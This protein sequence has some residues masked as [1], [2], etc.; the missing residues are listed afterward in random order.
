[1]F[2]R[3][4]TVLLLLTGI[5]SCIYGQTYSGPASGGVA[6]GATISTD[7]FSKNSPVTE[8]KEQIWNEETEYSGEQTEYIDF[9]YK[10]PK[11]GSNY[12]EDPNAD[13][14][15][16]STPFP[17]L[18]KDFDGIP[19]GNS[20]PPDP[21]I[22]VGP[23]NIIAVVNTS[24]RI[25][26]KEGN[27]LKTISADS[28]FNNVFTN[29]GAFDPKVLYDVID[30]RWI[31]VWLQQN[32][33]A[34]TA[35]LLLSVSDD[36]DPLGTWYNWA[37]PANLN[38]NTNSDT[39]TDYQG[40]GYDENAIY[41]TGN[42][43]SFAVGGV[44]TFQYAKIRIIPKAQLYANTAGPCSWQD[45]WNINNGNS[46]TIRP[47]LMYTSA[48]KYYMV[49][50]PYQANFIRVYNITDPLGTPA[51]GLNNIPVTSYT[52]PGNP[53][54]LGG[55]TNLE[56]GGSYLRNEP[57]FRDGFLYLV[58]AV[59]NPSSPGYSALHYVKVNVNTNTT[60]Q[61]YVFG[62]TG[63]WHFYPSID[64]DIN[65]NVALAYSRS[66]LNEYAGAF[67]TGRFLSDPPGFMGSQPIAEGQG[68]YVV[69]YGGDRNRWGDYTGIVL[70]PV[71]QTSFWALSEYV[72]ATNTWGTRVG[73]IS[74][75]PVAGPNL[76]SFIDSLDFGSIEVGT[77]STTL[78]IGMTNIGS[79]D[80][81]I[82]DVP[83]ELGPFHLLNNL[84]LPLT[85]STYDSLVLDYSYQPTET[86]PSAETVTITSNS[87]GFQDIL[88]KG[89]GYEIN[90]AVK[91]NFYA[92]SGNVNSGSLYTINPVTGAGN[93]IGNADYD[94]V[95]VFKSLTLDPHSGVLYGLSN[96]SGNAV[97][98]RINSAIGDA[99]ALYS[100][101]LTDMY[102]ITFDSS[103]TLYG[104]Q[105]TGEI[106][107]IDL[108]TGSYTFKDTADIMINSAAFDL[109]TNT[110]Y[111]TPYL[112][113][114]TNKD[115]I[116]TID[117]ETGTSTVVGNTGLNVLTNDLAFDASGNM[118]G[119]TGSASQSNDFISIDK[120]TGAGTI[121]GSINYPNI[122]GLAFSLTGITGLEP[123]DKPQ[124]PK[125]YSLKQNYPNPF[126]P[127]TKIEYTLPVAASVKVVIYN[128]LGEV[129]DVLVNSQ[130]NAGTHT[131]VWNSEDSHGNKAGSGV[132]FYELKANS[133]NGSDF[134]Q[135]RKMILLK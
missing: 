1:M 41:V 31:M 123:A 98:S 3:I 63:Y 21:Y 107:T 85:L 114:G 40:V 100:L 64:V 84:S 132:Y 24:F 99:Y 42:Q 101:P 68:N 71:D 91:D 118:Y 60:D 49:E 62:A 88:L 128:L 131:V 117:P 25:F 92:V 80:V 108:N 7:D 103:G 90:P 79:D 110:L 28:W 48:S 44:N 106:Y 113:I 15:N 8:P 54:Q 27:I 86:G 70:D 55:G 111:A 94:D 32:D 72:A 10:T 82:S 43:W 119:V 105:K 93:L 58:H 78:S 89:R 65:G 127:S 124:M 81:V 74:I 46:F 134:T 19:M 5:F 26:D 122:T 69:T 34:H 18:L 97:I 12:Y 16:G 23:D 4:F 37:L 52:S 87:P 6:S 53:S 57:K 29:P 22:A 133:S 9:G 56:G 102:S 17:F 36:S 14:P 104:I 77:T 20:I 96:I 121:I 59:A 76:I 50:V 135:V 51:L 120:N 112:I 95:D 83:S 116:Y 13:N 61:D 45:I 2:K 47:S 109:T 115:R 33:G 129:V 73:K 125:D 75:E 126:N 11:E 30:Q 39:W 67:F 35:N 66:S 130:Q 38:G